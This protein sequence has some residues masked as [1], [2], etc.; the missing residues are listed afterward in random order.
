MKLSTSS[1][2]FCIFT[3][4]F[5]PLAYNR[6]VLISASETPN[7]NSKNSLSGFTSVPTSSNRLDPSLALYGTSGGYLSLL[8]LDL[9]QPLTEAE[10]IFL[11]ATIRDTFNEIHEDMGIDLVASSVDISRDMVLGDGK[12]RHPSGGS[13]GS[14]NLRGRRELSRTDVQH[15]EECVFDLEFFTDCYSEDPMVQPRLYP[16]I[17]DVK[18]PMVQPRPYPKIDDVKEHEFPA[19]WIHPRPHPEVVKEKLHNFPNPMVQPRAFPQI[20]GIKEHEFPG[21]WIHPR[22]PPQV[23]DEEDH[24]V[25]MSWIHPFP[26]AQVDDEEDHDIG[27]PWVHQRPP[28]KKD[29]KK[30][31]EPFDPWINPRPVPPPPA[32]KPHL[33]DWKVLIKLKHGPF[34]RFHEVVKVNFKG[35]N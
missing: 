31:L 19:P 16:K 10:A 25:P 23:E 17:D 14:G 15:C 7:S 13:I 22:P 1:T 24:D 33:M 34:R 3:Y 26:L 21:P 18:G 29:D 2:L 35:G 11:G 8:G 30:K 32:P 5:V 28:P 12:A 27:G 20:D 9:N 4:T 6:S